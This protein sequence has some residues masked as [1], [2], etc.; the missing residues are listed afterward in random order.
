MVRLWLLIL[1]PSTALAE[2]AVPVFVA[3]TGGVTAAYEGDYYF[4]VGGGP[5][6]FDCSGDRKPDLYVPGGTAAGSMWVN[7]SPVGG[8]LAF[9]K[10]N[11]G[12]ELVGVTG[13]Y[14]LDIDGDGVLDL[15]LMRLGQSQLMRGLGNCRFQAANDLWGFDAPEDW[16]TA[17]AATFEAGA[18]WP[19]LAFGAYIDREASAFPWGSC[20][21]NRLY[22][23]AVGRFDPPLPLTP[24]YC[25]L[26]MLFTDWNGSGTASLRVSND[27]EYYKGGQEQ[28]WHLEPG[29]EPRLWSSDEGWAR[30]RIWGMGIASADVNAD[31]LPDYFLTSMADNKL[32]VLKDVAAGVPIYDD[33]AGKRGVTAHRPYVGGD[34]RP[35]T[36][37]HA[38]FGDVNNDGL[39]DLFVVKGNV[40]QM[41]DFAAKDPNNLLLQ[42]L[43]GAFVEVGDRA[44]VASLKVGRG[45]AVVDLNLDGALDL[46]AVNRWT[47]V[48]IW[49]QAAPLGSW[50]QV[51][52]HLPGANRDAVGAVLEVRRGTAVERREVSVGGGHAGGQLGWL[53]LGLGDAD[54]VR[55][56]VIWPGLGAGQWLR[57]EAGRFYDV[58]PNGAEP[59]VP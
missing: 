51:A 5:A 37:W 32:Q 6:V 12:A 52:L 13:A 20:T 24:S 56:R 41:P 55:I 26:S 35:S 57:L 47:G 3:D 49:R 43:D 58:T 25:A 16:T 18:E 7:E 54:T 38:Q 30:L 48:E 42:G 40:D 29:S 23:G 44:S 4:M 50:V 11:S 1:A 21:E 28:L 14:P 53:H 31:G 34:V 2:P 17:F 22:R 9:A 19:T 46:V 27:R 8:A 10:V 59:M 45:G 36:A 15:V 39:A 33:I